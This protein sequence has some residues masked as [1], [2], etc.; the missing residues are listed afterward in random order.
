MEFKIARALNHSVI[1]DPLSHDFNRRA[2]KYDCSGVH[3]VAGLTIKSC[4]TLIKFGICFLLLS[5]N[6]PRVERISLKQSGFESLKIV[7]H[8]SNSD[9]NRSVVILS[10]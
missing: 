1:I 5:D 10:P 7:F 8:I 6:D 2:V 3:E 9:S 4:Q